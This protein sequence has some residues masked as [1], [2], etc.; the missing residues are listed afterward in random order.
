MNSPHPGLHQHT[1]LNVQQHILLIGTAIAPVNIVEQFALRKPDGTGVPV[2]SEY[3]S[4][5][6]CYHVSL[7]IFY[8]D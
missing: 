1:L 2:S 5:V 6:L 7:S 4:R 3:I 8:M